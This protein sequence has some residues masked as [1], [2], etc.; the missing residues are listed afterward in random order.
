MWKLLAETPERGCSFNAERLSCKLPG[1]WVEQAKDGVVIVATSGELLDA[2]L[3]P[4]TTYQAL[5]IDPEDAGG[6]AWVVNGR[7][8]GNNVPALRLLP[9]SEQLSALERI[10][11]RIVLGE[12]VRLELEG[13]PRQGA[14]LAE[15][16]PKLEAMRPFL[17]GLLTFGPGQDYAGEK[18]LLARLRFGSRGDRATAEA[19]WQRNEIEQAAR[20]LAAVLSAWLGAPAAK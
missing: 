17:Q 16:A 14:S 20:S 15:L 9:G 2:M 4:G 6:G 18:A 5:G 3:Q 11:A 8:A 7:I 13:V 19:E 10:E 12:P 1:F